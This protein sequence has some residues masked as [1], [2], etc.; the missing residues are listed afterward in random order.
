MKNL[1]GIITAVLIILFFGFLVMQNCDCCKSISS[2]EE[3]TCSKE[4][5]ESETAQTIDTP[6]APKTIEEVESETTISDTIIVTEINIDST[7]V[8]IRE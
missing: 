2:K 8:E 1:T 3:V 5:S 4:K 7:E 6:N